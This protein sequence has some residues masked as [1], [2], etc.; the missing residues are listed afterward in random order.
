M[1]LILNVLH[2]AFSLNSSM[3][4]TA[5]SIQHEIQFAT[6]RA[7]LTNSLKKSCDVKVQYLHER[8]VI[9]LTPKN[10]TPTKTIIYLHGGAYVGD[11]QI[12]HWWIIQ[13]LIDKTAAS[14]I[15]PIYRLAPH[16]TIDSELP[17]VL[18]CYDSAKTADIY[19]AGDSA[20]GGLAMALAIELRKQ[21]KPK[22]KAVFLFSP[23]LDATMTNPAI[24]EVAPN[25]PMLDK[26]GLIW[27]GQVWAGTRPTTDPQVSPIYDELNDLPDLHIYQGTY[28]IFIADAKRFAEKAKQAGTVC[29]LHIFE[30]AFHV[31]MGATI[32]PESKQV[33]TDIQKVMGS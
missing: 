4:H 10:K 15:V 25:D 14:V 23:W 9:S 1:S 2:K 8:Q 22:P 32:A 31:F 33:F 3:L 21:N 6:P 7:D 26:G 29:H 12:A 13:A 27:C 11:L 17:F 20:G 5:A 16:A 28:D 24:D 30:K 18:A 19:L